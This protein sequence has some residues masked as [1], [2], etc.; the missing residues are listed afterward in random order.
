MKDNL[1]QMCTPEAKFLVPDWGMQ[2]YGI[3]LSYQLARLHRLADRYDNPMSQSTISPSLGLRI[4]P[5]CC[6]HEDLSLS[7]I[8]ALSIVFNLSICIL[9]FSLTCLSFLHLKS[10]P[11]CTENSKKIFPEMKLR[12][13]VPN[14]CI[15]VSVSDLYI[16]M[17][18]TTILPRYRGVT[19]LLPGWVIRK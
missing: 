4:W 2:D 14:F 15:H 1:S 13:L 19:V 9:S 12:G 11:H 18:D 8:T 3:G 7:V 6:R 10:I 5:Q 17:I 16:P